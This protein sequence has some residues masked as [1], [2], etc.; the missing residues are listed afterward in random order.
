MKY[1]V[2]AVYQHCEPTIG[3]FESIEDAELVY[4]GML[5]TTYLYEC[6]TGKTSIPTLL[7]QKK[8]PYEGEM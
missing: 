7:K 1:L 4:T 2:I 5:S 8:D 3:V 6:D